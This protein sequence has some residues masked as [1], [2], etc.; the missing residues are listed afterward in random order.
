MSTK[1]KMIARIADELARDDLSDQIDLAIDDA[2]EAFR[3]E[4]FLFCETRALTFN[5]VEGQEFYGSDDL[6]DIPNI[7]A[8]D[9]VTYLDGNTVFQLSQVEPVD[10][11]MASLNGTARGSP[12]SFAY[13]GE[14]IR[15]YP[16]PSNV[17]PVRITGQLSPSAPAAPDTAGNRWMTDGERLVRA[18]AKLELALHVV[19]DDGLAQRMNLVMEDYLRQMSKRANRKMGT[20]VIR[21]MNL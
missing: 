1:A 11:E 20:G 14:Q 19:N 17:W 6:A 21:P 7:I 15:I 16:V 18:R 10:I 3:T 9:F 4:R 2:I 8:F 5:T 12:S 13:F